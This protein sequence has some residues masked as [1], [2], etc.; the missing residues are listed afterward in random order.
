MEDR[1]NIFSTSY[2]I[3]YKYHKSLKPEI[4]QR[5]QLFDNSLNPFKSTSTISK[6]NSNEAVVLDTL[7][8]NVFQRSSEIAKLSDGLFDV[9]ISP[10]INA[11]GFGFKNMD[12]VTA[13]QIDSLKHIVGY[14]KV[15]LDEGRVIKEDAR[16]TLN[17]SAIAKGYSC[18]VIAYLLDSYGV[19]DYMIEIGGEIK[20]KG[21]NAKGKCWQIAITKPLQ[22]DGLMYKASQD[23]VKLCNKSLATSG[24][25]HK[26]YIKDGKRYAHTIDPRTGYPAD[27]NILSAT[28]I[29]DDCMTADA[30]ATVFML[31][32]TAVTRRIAERENLSYMLIM[33][34]EGDDFEI[35]K[36]E[37]FNTYLVY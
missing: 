6:V 37:N 34:V 35:V 4:D 28:V 31:A 33:G 18:D 14:D 27:N 36:S 7:F 2:S 11:W 26:Y 29:A 16:M 30:F 24:S 17:M 8:V 23:V 22:E 15:R 10:L 19:D 32:D 20:T 12:N 21:L 5:L 25:Y 1:G 3:K 13:S 9:T